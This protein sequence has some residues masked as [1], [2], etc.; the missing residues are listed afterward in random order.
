MKN[1][2]VGALATV[3]TLA[4]V[5]TSCAESERD[6]GTGADGD[7]GSDST[8]TEGDGGAAASDATFVFGAAGA[9]TTFDPFYASDGETFRVTRQIYENLIG[10]EEGGTEGVPELATSWESEDGL[11]WTFE[12]QEGVKFHDG[13][14][15]DAEAVCANFERWADQNEAGQNPSGAYYYGNDFGFGE[16]SLYE[17]CE[18]TDDL[19][20]EVVVSRV[21]GKFPMVLSQS[22]YA[23][24]SP[25]AMEEYDANGIA[26]EGEAFVFPEYATSHPTGTG[27][28]QF[29]GYDNAGG[30]V[31]LTRFDDYWGDPAGVET[32][33]F[34]IVPD[35]NARRQELE[36][37]TIQGYDLPNP[38]D[39]QALEDSGNQVLIR[40]PFNILYLALNPVADPQLEDPLVRQ[41]L[42]HALNREQFVSTQLPEGA[43]VATQF[44]PSTVSGYNESI[45]AYEYDP[46]KAQQLL[47]EAGLS[48]LTIELWYPSEVTRPYMPD[49]QRVYD[50]VKADWEAAGIT[51][52]TVT[53]PW[54]GGYIDDT[55]NSRAPAF[56]LGWTGDLNSADNFLCAFFCGDDN[57]FGTSAYDWHEEL[58]EQIAAADAEAD[59]ETRTQMYEELNAQIMS[60]DWLPGLPL[61]HSPPAIVVGPNVQGMVA[62][63]LTAENFATVTITE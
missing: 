34:K 44:M 50:A 53:K 26:L 37:G 2:K 30:T 32:L 24:Q 45:E 39:W 3:A 5:L 58:Q 60:P 35:E 40:D 57:Q 38:V 56:F 7:T 15:F 46:E 27:P 19:T 6:S 9:P 61:S 47:E 10:I 23:I 22:S 18:A 42:Y 41:A 8:Q 62:S 14:D 43:E 52:E 54:A 49:P 51:V 48:D 59:E 36:A 17:S 12:L 31:T 33:V 4:L 25:T 1:R 55:Q 28:F 16:D 29:E 11:T 13:T 63:P 20:A 21:T